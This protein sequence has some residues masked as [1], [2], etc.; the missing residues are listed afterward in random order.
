MEACRVASYICVSGRKG[1]VDVGRAN[2][3][4]VLA[5]HGNIICDASCAGDNWAFCCDCSAAVGDACLQQAVTSRRA[6]QA[7]VHE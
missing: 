2:A 6:Q 1:W 4:C 5:M 7:F 3:C